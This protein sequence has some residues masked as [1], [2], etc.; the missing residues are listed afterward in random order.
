MSQRKGKGISPP[1]IYA[2]RLACVLKVL[3]LYSEKQTESIPMCTM[4]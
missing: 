3:G 4:L 2:E 1:Q